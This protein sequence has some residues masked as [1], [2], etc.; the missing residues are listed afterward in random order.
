MELRYT[1]EEFVG[2]QSTHSDHLI[3]PPAELDGLLDVLVDMVDAH[4]GSMVIGY[5]TAMLLA[6]RRD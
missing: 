3:L 6:R 4:G 5:T 1:T 2:L